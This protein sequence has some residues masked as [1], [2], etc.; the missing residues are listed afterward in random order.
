MN[1]TRRDTV[2]I[3]HLCRH[4]HAQEVLMAGRIR[5][6]ATTIQY[7]RACLRRLEVEVTI[8]APHT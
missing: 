1:G 2:E 3:I 7:D 4:L 5:T 6:F 8:T